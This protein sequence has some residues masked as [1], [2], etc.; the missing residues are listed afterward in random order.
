MQYLWQRDRRSLL[1]EMIAAGL[2]AVLVKVSG[3]G[4]DPARHLGKDLAS[5]MPTFDR[6]SSRFGLDICG[7]GGEYESMVTDCPA[8]RCRIDIA[9]SEVVEDPN[10]PSVGHLKVLATILLR[11]CDGS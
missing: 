4:L 5:L 9:R 1:N 11:V 6:L 3:G 10:D 2:R 7:E 8:F